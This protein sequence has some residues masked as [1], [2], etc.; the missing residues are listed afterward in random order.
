MVSNLEK[1]FLNLPTV[2][3]FLNLGLSDLENLTEDL[4]FP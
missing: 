4:K 1:C 3:V 2:L